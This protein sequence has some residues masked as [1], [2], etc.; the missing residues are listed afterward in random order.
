MYT[1]RNKEE[2]SYVIQES[3]D[4][5]FSHN[6]PS[7]VEIV[8]STFDSTANRDSST[9]VERMRPTFAEYRDSVEL[10]G[11]MKRFSD[12]VQVKFS[13]IE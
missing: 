10:S 9:S 12:V 8:S 2:V 11:S 1:L 6:G 5:Y 4:Y 3:I 13:E 7:S